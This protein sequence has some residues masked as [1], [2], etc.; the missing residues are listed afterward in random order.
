MDRRARQL[1]VGALLRRERGLQTIEFVG[2]MPL[3]VLICLIILQFSL[4]GYAL[5]VANAAARDAARAAAASADKQATA[6]KWAMKSANPLKV[7]SV[8]A[9]S[10]GE[11]LTVEVKVEVP[12][13]KAPWMGSQELLITAKAVMPDEK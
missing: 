9:V 8:S 7:R 1:A 6:E 3:V 10:S 13:V 11:N 5:V 2:L 12:M 4:A